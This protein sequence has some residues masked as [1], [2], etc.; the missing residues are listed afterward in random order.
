MPKTKRNHYIPK[1]Y[2][3]HF[4]SLNDPEKVH[5]FDKQSK[6]WILTN[7]LNAGAWNDFYSD[8]DEKWLSDEVE[9]P[10]GTALAKLRA[11]EP[12][13]TDERHQVALYWES[14]IKRVPSTRRELLKG[15]PNAFAQVREGTEEL[16]HKYGKTPQ[17][18]RKALDHLED[19]QLRKPLSM[20]SEIARYQWTNQEII[21]GLLGMDWIVL[22][23]R[24]PDRFLT[25]DSPAFHTWKD[26]LQTPGSQLAFPLSSS[27]ALVVDRRKSRDVLIDHIDATSAQVK[28]VNRRMIL[29]SERFIYS[30]REFPC[31][32]T[33]LLVSEATR[34]QLPL[35]HTPLATCLSTSCG[36]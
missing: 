35:Q 21:D 22:I 15:A 17:V 26:G 29:G 33:P 9:F 11:G 3:R 24:G 27:A 14:M 10:A 8:E 31:D 36:V 34:V 13:D 25:G 30:R 2:L 7:V 20:T 4:A 16:S 1:E 12:I 28:E 19:E 23:S 32:L 6:N 5:M 18:I